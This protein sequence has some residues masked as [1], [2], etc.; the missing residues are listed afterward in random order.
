LRQVRRKSSQN[1][2]EE[3]SKKTAQVG[4]PCAYRGIQ[5]ATG[6]PHRKSRGGKTVRLRRRQ[7]QRGEKVDQ[8]RPTYGFGRGKDLNPSQQQQRKDTSEREKSYVR[9]VSEDNDARNLA[10][11]AG[12]KAKGTTVA[13]PRAKRCRRKEKRNH[14]HTKGKHL[15]LIVC[16][17]VRVFRQ[18][19]SGS[20]GKAASTQKESR[21]GKVLALRSE[22]EPTPEKKMSERRNFWTK[23]EK[24]WSSKKES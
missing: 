13:V 24:S 8:L 10:A 5:R 16:Q 19:V 4:K 12:T 11:L 15:N 22:E 20:E 7:D 18:Q 2:Y 17:Q 23:R 14:D 21:I 9:L 3:R 1:C 6:S